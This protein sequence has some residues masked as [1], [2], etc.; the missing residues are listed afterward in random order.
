MGGLVVYLLKD[1]EAECVAQ[2]DRNHDADRAWDKEWVVEYS[3]ADSS[4]TCIVHLHRC[5]QRWVGRQDK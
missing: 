2:Q 4:R 5:Q 1:D 3:L